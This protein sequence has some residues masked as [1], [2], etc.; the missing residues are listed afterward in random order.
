MILQDW[1]ILDDEDNKIDFIL[2]YKSDKKKKIKFYNFFENNKEDQESKKIFF[3]NLGTVVK[4]DTLG[5][6][7]IKEKEFI[8]KLNA[9][10]AIWLVE[11]LIN[12]EVYFRIRQVILY[13]FAY[14][15]FKEFKYTKLTIIDGTRAEQKIII[16]YTEYLKG[17]N[18]ENH[19]KYLRDIFLFYGPTK[20][21]NEPKIFLEPVK[22]TAKNKKK[23]RIIL[24][25]EAPNLKHNLYNLDYFNPK[26]SVSRLNDNKWNLFYKTLFFE[27]LPIERYALLRRYILYGNGNNK[28][29]LKLIFQENTEIEKAYQQDL[30]VQALI[31]EDDLDNLKRFLQ[32]EENP[33][34][35]K[36]LT[37]D[38]RWIKLAEQNYEINNFLLEQYPDQYE[39][40]RKYFI[41]N[42][43][44]SCKNSKGK[45][46][47]T[48][49][50]NTNIYGKGNKYARK[51]E[52]EFWASYFYLEELGYKTDKQKIEQLKLIWKNKFLKVKK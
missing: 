45:F 14:V 52:L 32:N 17:F 21:R 50:I 25:F 12:N 36:G 3:F 44:E 10:K 22:K 1:Q 7:F 30:I 16:E 41:E 5:L 37:Y 4:Y 26:S 8:E 2:M 48:K 42:L 28:E 39:K 23:D 40:K 35:I 43:D 20:I 34:T 33:M 49:M 38:S 15:N 9:Q 27:L 18:S 46:D 29:L 31:I 51:S 11:Y 6:T 19:L 13:I 47:G 24:A